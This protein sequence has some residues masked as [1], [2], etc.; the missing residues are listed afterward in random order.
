MNNVAVKGN[1]SLGPV[2]TIAANKSN[3]NKDIA[4]KLKGKDVDYN[5]KNISYFA[6]ALYNA[7]QTVEINLTEVGKTDPQL[8]STI[9][10]LCASS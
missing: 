10:L 1:L 7:P 2:A 9:A 5:G 4:F 6:Q 8:N 3:C